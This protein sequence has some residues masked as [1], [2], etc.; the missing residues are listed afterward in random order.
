M[1][2]NEIRKL[3]LNFF[4][5]HNHQLVQSSPLVPQNDPTLLFTNS[6]MVQFKN[7]FTGIETPPFTAAT[8]S[9]KCLR[10]GGK[11]NDLENV[12]YTGRHHTFFEMLGNFSFGEYFK[13]E[14]IYYAH[15]FVT[16][17]LKI[18]PKRLYYTVYHEDEESY[19]LWR[20]IAGV[21]E[22]KIIKIDNSDNFWSMGET[23]PC[24]PCTEIFYDYGSSVE[25]GLPGTPQQDG[26]RY[27]EI[28]NLVFMQYET[29]PD[30]T[31]VKLPKPCVDTG[32]GL[33][34]T[35]SVMQGFTDNYNIDLFETLINA[36]KRICN[37]GE[38]SKSHRV[39]A[40]HLRACAFLIADGILPGNEGRQYVLRRIIRRAVRH[41]HSLGVKKVSFYKMAPTL[42]ELMGASYPELRAAQ[43]LIE[44]TLE[45]EEERF[46]RTIDQGMKHLLQSIESISYGG[47]LDGVV[48][49]KLYDTYGFPLDLTLD[50]LKEKGLQLNHKSFEEAMA[51]QKSRARKAWKGEAEY[52]KQDAKYWLSLEEKLGKTQFVG[53]NSSSVNAKILAMIQ[54]GEEV[55]N[56]NAGKV[57]IV[58]DKTSFYA[59]SGGQVGDKGTISK[60]IVKDTM[61][62]ANG[63]FVHDVEVREP[64]AVG[65]AVSVCIDNNSRA[66]IKANHSATHLL[67]S[68]LRDKFGEHVVQKGSL[69]DD[70]KLRFDFTHQ[71]AISVQELNDIELKVNGMIFA[72]SKVSTQQMHHEEALQKGAMALF[73][74]K[75]GEE[76][77]VVNIGPSLELCGGT[78]VEY[79]GKIGMF[80]IIAE[81]S[82]A[83]GVRRITALTGIRAMQYCNSQLNILNNTAKQLKVNVL[84]FEECVL[85]MQAKLSNAN[86]KLESLQIESMLCNLEAPIALKGEK[87]VLTYFTSIEPKLHKP[88]I[89]KIA[90]QYLDTNIICIYQTK[91]KISIIAKAYANS[92]IFDAGSFMKAI[93]QF[94]GGRGGGSKQF[95]QGGGVLAD[96]ARVSRE[97]L[98]DKIIEIIEG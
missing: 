28:W 82:V 44:S 33:E 8:S 21:S 11:H 75:Y 52:Q 10:A 79:T 55:Q 72:N 81:E 37:A 40:D 83:S 31:R 9:Q 51:S 59:E 73:G 93:C 45:A 34:R 53:Y 14:A 43:K 29:L 76:V 97:T 50:I 80:K 7:Y 38:N 20:K 5:N 18:D 39:I 69:V 56:A 60:S 63:L 65:D 61:K 46:R 57:L 27:V 23:G 88:V 58:L 16:K 85:D 94:V 30:G 98:Y 49:F 68:A 95:A 42:V 89:E 62:Y 24:G 96:G 84:E 86:K 64:L 12:G 77:R 74:E 25:G 87:F 90:K 15:N 22:S 19:N 32:M 6:G 92:E 91:G 36:S 4:A 2:L 67:H 26:D 35:A 47:I 70:T 1:K 13:E 66:L 41:I 48:A 78:H 17:H 3:F 54:N 71:N